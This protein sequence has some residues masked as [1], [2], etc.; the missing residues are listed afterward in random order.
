MTLYEQLEVERTASAEEIKRA[1]FRLV[2]QFTPEKAPEEFMRIRRAYEELSDE[3]TRAD[4][5]EALLRFA[6]MPDDVLDT[7]MEAERLSS[8]MLTADSIRLLEKK[9]K[10]FKNGSKQACAISYALSQAY[11]DIGKS[12]KA[13][14]IAEE[15]A[16]NYPDNVKYL[17]LAAEACRERGW[18]KKAYGYLSEL[19]IL[20]PGNEDDVLTFFDGMDKRAGALG[21]LVETIEM[22]GGAAPILCAAVL[23]E[24]L[25]FDP[26]VDDPDMY[27]QMDLFAE[28]GSDEKPWHD[29]MFAAQKLTEHSENI[30]KVKKT[31]LESLL[32]IGILRGMYAIDRYDI[33]PHIDRVIENIGAEEIFKTERYLLCATAYAAIGAVRAG[34]PKMLAAHSVMCFFSQIE[35][36]GENERSDYRNE[37][38]AFELD[39]MAN[40]SSLKKGLKRY[41][42][43]FNELYR[44]SAG[45]MDAVARYNEDKYISEFNR[46]VTK[47]RHVNRRFTLEWLGEDDDFEAT[48]AAYHED[49]PQR[50][51][52][53]RVTKI[54][55][56]E[57]CPCG[58]GKKYKKCCGM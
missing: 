29:I 32:D 47:L 34:I 15:L 20:D 39:I 23:C 43:D 7:L 2:R 5:D 30:P 4:Y 9:Q 10:E 33:L 50:S 44:H 27:E 28:A 35:I 41:R 12:G 1:Y 21:K 13:V 31:M 37:A 38:L 18:T 51:E 57:P 58:S 40:Y 26:E 52:P 14:E 42:E 53:V 48:A 49:A 54:G 17:R 6:D 46:R 24:C 55:R 8:R 16:R 45:F 56:N 19:L 11:L 36:I 3:E 22:H 25:M